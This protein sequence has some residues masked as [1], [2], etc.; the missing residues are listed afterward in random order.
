MAKDNRKTRWET[1]KFWDLV[2]LILEVSRY[3]GR[4]AQQP[5]LGATILIPCHVIIQA[6]A[7]LLKNVHL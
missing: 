7:I 1:F 4:A 5:L 6:P 3:N 2:R